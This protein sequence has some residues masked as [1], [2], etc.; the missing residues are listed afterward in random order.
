MTTSAQK[1]ESELLAELEAGIQ[2]TR[3]EHVVFMQEIARDLEDRKK[4]LIEEHTFLS[5][6]ALQ[7][8]E[9]LNVCKEKMES[10]ERQ[11]KE[12]DEDIK[13]HKEKIAKYLNN[14][15]EKIAKEF[16]ISSEKQEQWALNGGFRKELAEILGK[17]EADKFYSEEPSTRVCPNCHTPIPDD[18]STCPNCEDYVEPAYSSEDEELSNKESESLAETHA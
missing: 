10:S 11:M 15:L 2:Q 17:T 4:Q 8:E 6:E 12:I 3:E 1:T 18:G 5:E 9:W 7:Y 13:K 14:T 16:D